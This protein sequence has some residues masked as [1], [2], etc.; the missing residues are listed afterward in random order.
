MTYLGGGESGTGHHDVY[1]HE[2]DYEG[3]ETQSVT[4]D[5]TEELLTTD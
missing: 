3:R 4:D 2:T 5:D 1:C